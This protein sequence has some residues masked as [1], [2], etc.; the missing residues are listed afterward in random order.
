MMMEK[1]D[2]F[3]HGVAYGTAGWQSSLGVPHDSHETHPTHRT[4]G[5]QAP[6]TV[7]HNGLPRP[8]AHHYGGHPADLPR[9]PVVGE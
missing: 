9:P 1:V 6:I 5:Q 7:G 2:C 8:L 4:P 3:L